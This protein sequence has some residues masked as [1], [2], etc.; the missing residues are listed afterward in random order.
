[1]P[2]A[3]VQSGGSILILDVSL[4]D[5]QWRPSAAEDAVGAA[6]ENWL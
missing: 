2:T 3:V 1:M 4:E 6:P 5:F